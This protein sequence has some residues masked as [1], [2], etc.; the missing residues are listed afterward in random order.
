[1]IIIVNGGGNYAKFA[2][3]VAS[4]LAGSVRVPTEMQEMQRGKYNRG[5]C[6]LVPPCLVQTIKQA[7][8]TV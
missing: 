2:F 5:L 1:M 7:V 8:S 6:M 3:T 4:H